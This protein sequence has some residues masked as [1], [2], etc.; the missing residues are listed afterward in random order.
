M[1]QETAGKDFHPWEFYYKETKNN[2][3]SVNDS[4]FSRIQKLEKENVIF[5][6]TN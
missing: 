1:S 4:L 2:I 6:Q 5:S 3:N